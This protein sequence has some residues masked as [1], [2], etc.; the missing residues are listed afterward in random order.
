[1]APATALLA[2]LLLPGW[3]RSVRGIRKPHLGL[4]HGVSDIT[5][6]TL[7]IRRGREHQLEQDRALEFVDGV[8]DHPSIVARFGSPLSF[9]AP[10]RL[11][12]YA[13]V[14]FAKLAFPYR[15]RTRFHAHPKGFGTQDVSPR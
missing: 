14:C 5:R 3:A 12:G 15:P 4:S 13:Q 11:H 10:G 1:V 7:L 6:D 9:D 2:A 8:H